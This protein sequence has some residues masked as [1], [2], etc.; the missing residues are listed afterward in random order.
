VAP[1][2]PNYIAVLFPENG[3]PELRTFTTMQGLADFL[4]KLPPTTRGYPLKG[5][6]L[7][8]T[9]GPFR[10]LVDGEQ[11]LPLFDAPKMGKPDNGANFGHVE[12]EPAAAPDPLYTELLNALPKPP[13]PAAPDEED[14]EEPLS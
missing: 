14:M 5:W 2:Q 11:I 7:K 10:Y 6:R 9:T 3:E 1:D 4:R 13:P 8:V 12:E